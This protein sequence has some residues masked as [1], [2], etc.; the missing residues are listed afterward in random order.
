MENMFLNVYFL[1]Y[2]YSCIT[3]YLN[4]YFDILDI[5]NVLYPFLKENHLSADNLGYIDSLS[6]HVPE[7][8]IVYHLLHIEIS[9]GLLIISHNS[10]NTCLSSVCL[11]CL[12]W[13]YI[14]YR[15]DSIWVSM[16]FSL[17]PLNYNK[18]QVFKNQPDSCKTIILNKNRWKKNKLNYVPSTK[19]VCFNNVQC[20]VRNLFLYSFDCRLLFVN[21]LS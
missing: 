21:L 7:Y 11:K 9:H 14:L 3:Y 4:Y 12:R 8:L 2:Q 1:L 18:I 20:H 13:T 15:N 19:W 5:F 17:V 6:I 10:S 16:I